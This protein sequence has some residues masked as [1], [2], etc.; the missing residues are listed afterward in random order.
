MNGVKLLRISEIH[1]GSIGVMT[2][3]VKVFRFCEEIGVLI[4]EDW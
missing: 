3:S 2:R 1:C 4:I